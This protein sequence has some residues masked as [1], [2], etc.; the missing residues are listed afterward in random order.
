MRIEIHVPI[1]PTPDY[2]LRVHYLAASIEMYGGLLAGSYKIVVTVGADNRV[3]LEALCPWTKFY[4]IEW[5]WVPNEEWSE[6][7]IFATAYGRF[8]YV[9]DAD[10]VLMID[11]DTLVTGS[12]LEMLQGAVGTSSFHATPGH[13]SPFFFAPDLDEPRSPHARW[14]EIYRHAGLEPPIF[15]MEHLAWPWLKERS[16]PYLDEMRFAPSYPNAGVIVANVATMRRIGLGIYEDLDYVNAVFRNILSGQVALSL[17]ISRLGLPWAPL[18]LR[19]N[20]PNVQEFYDAYREEAAEVRV[21][22][23]L[24]G[25]QINRG[26][27]FMSYDHVERAM[28]KPDLSPLNAFLADRLRSVHVA[29]VLPDLRALSTCSASPVAEL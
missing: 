15:S 21:L 1:S 17:S 23:F 5:R 7:G 10:V 3:D 13:Y 26:T 29:K 4:P 2:L 19:Y 22:H 28:D 18:P 6:R 20:F 24:Q 16:M 14:R 27:D 12:L 25:T 8:R 9:F 11:G